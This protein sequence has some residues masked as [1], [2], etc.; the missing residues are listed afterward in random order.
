MDSQS[1]SHKSSF[2]NTENFENKTNEKRK[3]GK[4]E[5]EIQEYA[6]KKKQEKKD[7][8]KKDKKEDKNNTSINNIK[9]MENDVSIFN[10]D[11]EAPSIPMHLSKIPFIMV[12]LNLYINIVFR[13]KK[14]KYIIYGKKQKIL[15][16]LLN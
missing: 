10:F 9:G 7:P 14:I 11:N 4:I 16:F 8:D 15:R 2:S 12:R 5:E 1:T 3:L 6:S 13:K